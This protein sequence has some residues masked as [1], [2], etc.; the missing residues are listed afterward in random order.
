MNFAYF[1]LLLT[2][3][4]EQRDSP[5]ASLHKLCV[6]AHH[7]G[8]RQTVLIV[9]VADGVNPG[10]VRHVAEQNHPL[11]ERLLGLMTTWKTMRKCEWARVYVVSECDS[12]SQNNILN[13]SS[14]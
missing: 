5:D 2:R 14:H 13:N 1:F 10:Q 3:S 6:D 9:P 8:S 4:K 7:V 12:E 11:E